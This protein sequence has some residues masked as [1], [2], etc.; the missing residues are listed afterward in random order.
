M[1]ETQVITERDVA[2]QITV[3]NGRYLTLIELANRTNNRKE[4]Q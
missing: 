4:K 3:K 1:N 2:K